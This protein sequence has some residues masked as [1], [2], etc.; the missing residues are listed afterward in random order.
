MEENVV[1]PLIAVRI[2]DVYAEAV[3]AFSDK[4]QFW[5]EYIK[6]LHQFKFYKY[7]S[8]VYEQML[9]VCIL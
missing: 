6:F 4:I 3:Q 8:E 1:V 2:K 7:I 5:N 9:M